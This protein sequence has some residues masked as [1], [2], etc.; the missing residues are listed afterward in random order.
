LRQAG[1]DVL[2]VRTDFPG[3][4]DAAILERG[5]TD[6]R[7]L[8]TLDKDFWQIAIQRKQPLHNGGVILFRVHPAVPANITPLVLG[9]MRVAEEWNGYATVVSPDR[10]LMVDLRDKR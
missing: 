8:L 10:V 3:A 5:Q 9:A 6:T 7:I 2:W 1:H 4:S